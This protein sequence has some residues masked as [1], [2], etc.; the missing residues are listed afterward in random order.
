M[1]APVDAANDA[2]VRLT[3]LRSDGAAARASATV[4]ADRNASCVVS[5][6]ATMTKKEGE[7]SEDGAD[8]VHH[9]NTYWVPVDKVLET[10]GVDLE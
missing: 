9:S 6:T 7:E 8:A 2:A 3:R 4:L 10:I 1:P 5:L